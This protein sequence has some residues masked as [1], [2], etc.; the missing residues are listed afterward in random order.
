MQIPDDIKSYVKK[1]YTRTA[2]LCGVVEAAVIL[3]LCLYGKRTFSAFDPF[4]YV[5][6]HVLLIL[7]P[8]LA[9]KIPQMILDRSWRGTVTRVVINTVTDNEYPGKPT[10]EHAYMRNDVYLYVSLGNGKTV[11]KKVYSGKARE[12]RFINTYHA[13]DYVLHVAG[14]RYV[15]KRPGRLAD[16]VICVVCSAEGAAEDTHCKSCGHTLH[17]Q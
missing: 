6:I 11:R 1:K 16:P 10:I 13:G 7:A 14:T 12:G 2:V 5:A 4:S 17:I 9:F 3:F 8:I 15:Q